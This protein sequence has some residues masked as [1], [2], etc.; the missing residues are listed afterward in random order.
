MRLCILLSV[1]NMATVI[2]CVNEFRIRKICEKCKYIRVK[3]SVYLYI[4][5]DIRNFNPLSKKKK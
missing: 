1:F 5:P 4:I 3:F 2:F